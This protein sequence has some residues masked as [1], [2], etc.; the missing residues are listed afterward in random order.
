MKNKIE[1]IVLG[2]LII[3]GF[4][5][6]SPKTPAVASVS[7]GSEYIATTTQTMASSDTL[8]TGVGTFGSVVITGANTGVMT[9]YDGTTTAVTNNVLASFPASTVAGTYTFDVRYIKG[10]LITI[11]GN[12]ATSTI[13]Y[14]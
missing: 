5:Y 3:A 12:A 14:R 2:L 1:I 7:Q 13:T 11:T 6:L 8:N 4:V 10:L 9:V